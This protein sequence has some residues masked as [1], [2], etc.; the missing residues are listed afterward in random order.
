[1]VNISLTT[2]HLLDQKADC[3]AFFVEENFKFSK[4]LSECADCFFPHLKKFMKERDFTGKALS[5]LLVP[6]CLED[7]TTNLIF[8]G[9]GKPSQGKKKIETENF[10]RAMGVAVRIAERNNYSSLAL[11][12]P[13]RAL[14]GVSVEYLAK[15]AATIFHMASYKFDK[16]LSEETKKQKLDITVSLCI[17]AKDKTAVAKGTKEGETISEAVNDA[18]YWVDSPASDMTPMQLANDAKAIAKKYGLKITVFDGKKAQELGMGGITAVS[19]GS[20]EDCRFV[21]M[22]YT[23]KKKSAKTIGFV[24]KGVTFDSGGLNLKP[25]SGPG[26]ME[27]M[28]DDMSGAATVIGAMKAIATL[29]PDVN[30]VGIV[31]LAENMPDGKSYKPGDILRFYNKKTAEVL[32]TDAEGRLVLADALS[33]AVKNFKLSALVDIATLTGACMHALGYF[34]CGMMSQHD[35]LSKKVQKA[36]DVSGD[37]VWALPF[38]DD[39]KPAIKSPVADIQNTGSRRYLAGTVTAGFFLQNF[40]GDVPWVHL[41]MAGTAFDVPDVSYFRPGATGFGV[42]LLTELAMDWS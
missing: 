8:L 12:L 36:S 20:A 30:V 1:M 5:S 23:S 34:F 40:V 3:I 7:G 33:Y 35:E 6:I 4:N 32:N 2:K 38:H 17:A 16:F 13:P 9:L 31:G 24:G 18:R 41:D 29:K 42:R 10:R 21:I 19:R 25:A 37:R 15:Q 11:E 39:F 26:A 28:R 27:S 22:E 14:F